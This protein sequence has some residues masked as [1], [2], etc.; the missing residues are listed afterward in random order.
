M[1]PPGPNKGKAGKLSK[2]TG[3]L[4]K[5]N[6]DDADKIADTQPT[7]KKQFPDWPADVVAPK[8]LRGDRRTNAN[9]APPAGYAFADTAKGEASRIEPV[10][11]HPTLLPEPER[12][13]RDRIANR[14]LIEWLRLCEFHRGKITAF[15]YIINEEKG[16]PDD[17][18]NALGITERQF[19]NYRT[20]CRVWLDGFVAGLESEGK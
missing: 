11:L 10:T 5:L 2:A 1:H 14:A 19:R 7:C 16:E 13:T 15:L 9:D 8:P 6:S 20:E 17:I 4:Q 18:A 3:P 12:L